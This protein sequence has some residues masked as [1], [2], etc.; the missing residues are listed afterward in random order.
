[1]V[2]L[3]KD[4][5]LIVVAHRGASGYMPENTFASFDRAVELGADMMELDVHP[6]K[7]GHLVVIHDDTVDRTTDGH[8]SVSSLTLDE[9]RALNAAAKFPGNMQQ[10][11]PTLAEVLD[12]YAARIPIAVEVKH[13]SSV[14]PGIER[15]VVDELERQSATDR[16]ELISFDLD[17]LRKLRTESK[18]VKTGFIFV[19]NMA[20]SA[21]L[22]R[23]DVDALHGRWDFL[24]PS[25]I[26][27]ARGLG[28]PTYAWT[29]NTV[30][31]IRNAMRLGPDGIV[32][33][34]PDRALEAAKEG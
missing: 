26:E 13:G 2:E 30:E 29:V 31:E 22:V 27:R 24:A 15:K 12:R 28:F 17:C 9:I 32:S 34:F 6:S 25:Q 1:M 19:G 33:N 11:V 4:D 3:T 21:E 8:G 18:R 5:G 7:D 20:S 10:R 14:Y 16:V 23:G